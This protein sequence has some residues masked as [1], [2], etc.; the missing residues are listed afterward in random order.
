M[1]RRSKRKAY[2]NFAAQADIRPGDF[3]VGS[4][5]SRA[6]ARAA[7]PALVAH[8]V[9]FDAPELPLH[10]ESSTCERFWWPNG[11]I[12]EMVWLDGRASDISQE[13][14]Y[15]FIDSFP[16]LP[17]RAERNIHEQS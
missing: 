11:A 12:C 4:V 1:R 7:M 5:E 13:E 15:K 9:I 17:D 2:R 16:I 3:P 6:A 10:L 14:L 8:T